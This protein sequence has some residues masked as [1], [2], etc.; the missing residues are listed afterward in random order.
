MM[1]KA[2]CTGSIGDVPYCFPRSSIEFQGNTEQNIANFNL[3][4]AYPDIQPWPSRPNLTWKSKFTTFWA[5]PHHNTW[6]VQ[7][8]GTKPTLVSFLPEASFRLRVLSLPA[9]VRPSVTKFSVQGSTY[10]TAWQP[11]A[12]KTVRRASRFGEFFLLNHIWSGIEKSKFWKSG[13][14]IF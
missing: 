1:H 3:N 6:P 5:C 13:K 14:W 12:S 7:Q 8:S 9:S 11:G 2:W 4:W 10:P